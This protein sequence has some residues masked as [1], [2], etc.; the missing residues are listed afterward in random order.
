MISSTIPARMAA[1]V[2]RRRLEGD[3]LDMPLV[4]LAMVRA[5]WSRFP[6]RG[7]E[8]TSI[9]QHSRPDKSFAARSAAHDHTRLRQRSRQR[10]VMAIG[11]RPPWLA[12]P[13]LPQLR[14][15]PLSTLFVPQAGILPW[16]DVW[17]RAVV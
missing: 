4:E 1:I 3:W 6:R 13:D 5:P 8:G 14:L 2:S 12:G 9:H 11:R 7:I 15:V 10:R 16:L 17:R